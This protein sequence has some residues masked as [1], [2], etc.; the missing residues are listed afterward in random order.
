MIR[1]ILVAPEIPPNTG[2][3]IRLAANTG[4][5]LHLVRPLG[6]QLDDR[7]MRRAGM[8]YRERAAF[9]IHDNFSN[10]K[11]AAGNG[12]MFAFSAAGKTPHTQL[13][14][15]P[16]DIFVFGCESVGLPKEILAEFPPERVLRIPMRPGNRS[17]NLSNAVAVAVMEA[18]RQLGFP[19]AE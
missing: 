10:A 16:D 6:F 15:Q 9:Q 11:T 12:K 2:N 1:V 17:L 5:E 3:V 18:W 8:D 14:Y 13:Q 19:G 4:A 7:E